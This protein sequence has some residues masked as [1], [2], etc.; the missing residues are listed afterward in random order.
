MT[1]ASEAGGSWFKKAVQ[2]G[3]GF[4]EPPGASEN[5]SERPENVAQRGQDL[6][7]P[8]NT[9]KD[10]SEVWPRLEVPL[11]PRTV[12]ITA[13]ILALL[14][15]AAANPVALVFWFF[16][17]VARTSLRLAGRGFRA[18]RS[19]L[20]LEEQA[21]GA[22]HGLLGFAGRDAPSCKPPKHLQPRI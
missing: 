20:A 11:G 15:A 12:P 14:L 6:G 18:V 7:E 1:R 8:P 21:F 17:A 9:S 13:A 10:L 16:C 19:C 2:R 22:Q 3:P 4:S 5:L